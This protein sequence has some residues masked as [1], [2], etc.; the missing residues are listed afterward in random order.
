MW[1]CWLGSRMNFKPKICYLPSSK[2]ADLATL[3]ISHPITPGEMFMLESIICFAKINI[4]WYCWRGSRLHFK[5][6][7]FYL[8]SSKTADLATVRIR[9]PITPGEMFMLESIIF[10]QG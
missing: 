2:T 1:Y 7:S 6:T 4:M 10:L 9:H 3:I 5:P 8:T